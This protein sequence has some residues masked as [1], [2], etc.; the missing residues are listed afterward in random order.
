[1]QRTNFTSHGKVVLVMERLGVAI[2]IQLFLDNISMSPCLYTESAWFPYPY[3]QNQ[4]SV[5]AFQI[6]RND[7]D[8]GVASFRIFILYIHHLLS[9]AHII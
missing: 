6:F 9:N 7:G 3:P 1:M 5:K 8:N 2:I 4:G